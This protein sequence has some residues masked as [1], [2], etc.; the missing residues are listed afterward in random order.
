M[1]VLDRGGKA[2]LRDVE[3]PNQ[4]VAYFTDLDRETVRR[5]CGDA[6]S[7]SSVEATTPVRRE[8]GPGSVRLADGRLPFPGDW[9][10]PEAAGRGWRVWARRSERD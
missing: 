10:A 5:K 9:M 2:R 3:V 4:T 6:V 7:E 8:T 1:S